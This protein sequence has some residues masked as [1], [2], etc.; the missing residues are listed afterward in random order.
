MAFFAGMVDAVFY[1]SHTTQYLPTHCSGAMVKSGVYFTENEI[2]EQAGP[3]LLAIMCFF[4]GALVS[5]ILTSNPDIKTLKTAALT[6]VGIGVI[7]LLASVLLG[8]EY[9]EAKYLA[10][11]ASGLQ[12]GLL[13]SITGFARTTHM[14]GTVTDVGLLVGQGM[15]KDT[16]TDE[17]HWWKC[18]TLATLVLAW[19]VGGGVAVLVFDLEYLGWEEHALYLVGGG[20]ICVGLLGLLHCWNEVKL[21]EKKAV[22]KKDQEGKDL[23]NKTLSHTAFLYKDLLASLVA[24]VPSIDNMPDIPGALPSATT[25]SNGSQESFDVSAH[26]PHV[27]A[28]AK[29]APENMQSDLQELFR[30]FLS[31]PTI[32]LELEVAHPKIVSHVKLAVHEKEEI[33][34][35]MRSMSNVD[36]S[37]K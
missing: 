15:N 22:E 23:A 37:D 10:G 1:L 3:M 12:N 6:T 17:S 21:E 13:T 34:R 9:K 28:L 32:V 14:T 35:V 30:L 4:V 20:V 8:L 31:H 29:T 5:G 26:K 25:P 7:L 11:L 16:W 27:E 18:R 33:S 2:E 19:V 36:G 24:I